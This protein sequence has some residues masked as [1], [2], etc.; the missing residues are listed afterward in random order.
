[1][2][3]YDQLK[4]YCP[5]LIQVMWCQVSLYCQLN[6]LAVVLCYLHYTELIKI[7]DKRT[8]FA[9]LV[10]AVKREKMIGKQSLTHVNT[11]MLAISTTVFQT[12][13]H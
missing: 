8:E 11:E 13:C 5:S 12:K 7:T 2:D 3:R 4:F 1:M 10:L 9:L 6:S